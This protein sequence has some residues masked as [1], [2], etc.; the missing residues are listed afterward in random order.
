[1]SGT[2]PAMTT[3]VSCTDPDCTRGVPPAAIAGGCP[4]PDCIKGVPPAASAAN[5]HHAWPAVGAV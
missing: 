1:V 2:Q 3:L 5:G 4:D